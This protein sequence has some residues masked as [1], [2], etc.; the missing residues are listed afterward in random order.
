VKE[1]HTDTPE[2]GSHHDDEFFV[3]VCV[4]VCVCGMLICG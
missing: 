3:C 4:R 1:N 2:Q